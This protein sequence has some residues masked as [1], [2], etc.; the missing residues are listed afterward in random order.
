MKIF[1]KARYPNIIRYYN[2]HNSDDEIFM[3]DVEKCI[4]QEYCQNQFLAFQSFKVGL[5]PS[6]KSFL[7]YFNE[8][9]LK[10]IKNAFYFILKAFFVLKLFTFCPDIQVM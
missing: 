2:Y 7:I 6:K 4:L 9:L 8:C 10:M 5:S 1:Y 3:S